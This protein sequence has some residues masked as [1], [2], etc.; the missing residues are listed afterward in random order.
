M[1]FVCPQCLTPGSLEIVLKIEL[2][3]DERSD[4]VAVQV[5]QC[6]RLSCGFR[7]LALYEESRRGAMD[8]V[9][10][11]GYRAGR[12]Q[13]KQIEELIAACPEPDNHSCDC[14]SHA[15]LSREKLSPDARRE[16]FPMRLAPG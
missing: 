2:P 6:K 9:N 4:E 10:H 16:S 7:G 3:P 1:P 11:I 8:S 13:V 12:Q 14:A 5:V 15:L